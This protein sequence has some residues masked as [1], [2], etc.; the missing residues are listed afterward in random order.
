[1]S[2]K[3]GKYYRHATGK[4]IFICGTFKSHVLG[5][6][7]MAEDHKGNFSPVGDTKDHT[8]NWVEIDIDEFLQ[9]EFG[10]CL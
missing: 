2:F 5:Y 1:M 7:L 8:I 10:H 4:K 9:I 3:I 6:I